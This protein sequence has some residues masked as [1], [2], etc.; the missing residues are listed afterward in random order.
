MDAACVKERGEEQGAA[1][2]GHSL[3]ISGTNLGVWVGNKEK[4]GALKSCCVMH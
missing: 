2:T 1:K 3:T 4:K